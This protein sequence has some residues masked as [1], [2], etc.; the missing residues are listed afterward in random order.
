MANCLL[1]NNE[2]PR[3]SPT[4]L[5]PG[6]SKDEIAERLEEYFNSI[7][8]EYLPLNMDLVPPSFSKPIER[9]TRE[10][11]IK[12]FKDSKKKPSSVPGDIPT[13][14]YSRF[15]QLLA[16]PAVIIF[17]RI[18]NEVRWPSQWT[19]EYVT[20]IPK[21]QAPPDSSE[22]RNIS[23]ISFLS[24]IMESLVL[25]MAS[26]LAVPRLN[27]YGG[28]PSASSTHFLVELIDYVT[29]SLEDNRAL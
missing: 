22:C 23:C 19:T 4:D 25:E 17:N 12:K 14:L 9:V 7:S 1:G 3:W 10:T 18:I 21:N 27:Q 2:K 16:N 26:E 28:E 13:H 5:Y 6:T 24:K 29:S 15:L 8:Q 11:V 20:I